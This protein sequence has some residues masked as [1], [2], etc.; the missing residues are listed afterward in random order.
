MSAFDTLNTKRQWLA[1]L[2]PRNVAGASVATLRIGTRAVLTGPGDTP[3]NAYFQA[4][5]AAPPLI[6]HALEEAGLAAVTRG[7]LEIDLSR[8][9]DG[10][11]SN[12]P[13]TDYAYDGHPVQIWIGLH[14]AAWSDHELVLSGIMGSAEIR[15][16]RMLVPV[17]GLLGEL[18]VPFQTS[19]F[20]GTGGWEGG[21]DHKD[22]TLPTIYGHCLNVPAD[23]VDAVNRRFVFGDRDVSSIDAVYEGGNS[24]GAAYTGDAAN[25]RVT[26]NV[27]P[28]YRLTLD[29]KGDATGSGFVDTTADI[30]QRMIVDRTSLSTADFDSDAWDDLA[31]DRPGEIG[32]W[33]PPGDT[34]SVADIVTLLIKAIGAWID[35]DPVTGKL[36]CGLIKPPSGTPE[37]IVSD[38]D[39]ERGR[40]TLDA[41]RVPEWKVPLFY[42]PNWLEMSGADLA[43]AVHGTAHEEFL[44]K[45]FRTT[46]AEDPDVKDDYPKSRPA[47]PRTTF[48]RDKSDAD[49]Q[50][51]AD[52][53]I[54]KK[55]RR[56]YR[57]SIRG[58]GFDLHIGKVLRV[59]H[60]DH[61]LAAGA[62]FVVRGIS[63]R[64]SDGVGLLLWRLVD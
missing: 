11:A 24:I 45:A 34:R 51:A 50:A 1:E 63:K 15:D 13:W 35:Q 16:G 9:G 42:G 58:R 23:Q 3:P 55:R 43:G 5:L 14:G 46:A 6:D 44:A 7:A 38:T 57:C 39:M 49:V 22:V 59:I 40:L 2:Q 10:Q 20:A 28:S 60:P 33:T 21:D 30:V 47:E 56:F 19:V 48:Y 54:R 25:A 53:A 36:T 41:E 26:P 8:G 62:D 17:R 12:W 32:H 4:R 52:L 18:D 37:M 64:R 61:N 27:A 31:T 29:A